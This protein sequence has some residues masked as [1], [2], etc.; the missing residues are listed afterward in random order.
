MD[1]LAQRLGIDP[2]ELRVRNAFEPGSETATRQ[3]LE[4]SV[5]LKQTLLAV[6]S[7]YTQARRQCEEDPVRGRSEGA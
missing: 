3:I 4:G 6:K 2:L 5:P 7:H 1:E